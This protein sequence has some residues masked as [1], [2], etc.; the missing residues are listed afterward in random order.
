MGLVAC[1]RGCAEQETMAELPRFPGSDGLPAA[2][3]FLQK[4]V[5]KEVENESS[6]S[7]GN[8]PKDL[9]ENGQMASVVFQP[10]FNIRKA[11]E[12]MIVQSHKFRALLLFF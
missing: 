11:I 4:V 5:R 8:F 12:K 9:P 3:N 1:I 7:P 2:D 6:H 10:R